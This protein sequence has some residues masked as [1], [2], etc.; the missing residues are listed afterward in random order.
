MADAR[1][2]AEVIARAL[3]GWDA[4][5]WLGRRREPAPA[6]LESSFEVAIRRRLRHEPVAYILGEREFYGRG[7]RV[8]PDVLI[9][10]PETELVID[11]ALALLPVEQP[12]GR[13]THRAAD[14][15]TGSG[16][17]AITLALE[18]PDVRVA[19]S[20]TSASALAVA[21]AN[22]SALDV[23]DRVRF[24]RAPVGAVPAIYRVSWLQNK[25]MVT[26]ATG[27]IIGSVQLNEKYT[28]FIIIAMKEATLLA[29]PRL[30][31]Q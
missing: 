6:F 18:R 21:A 28:H 27:K 25:L 7:F 15:G 23:G 30:T 8:T 3:L 2:D 1:L 29:T 17:I 13:A 24:V 19:A 26:D 11:E 12:G 16:C 14:V 22:A 4:A 10:R 31:Y 20:D 9:P 5:D